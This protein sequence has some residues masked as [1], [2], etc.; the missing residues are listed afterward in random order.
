M[1]NGVFMYRTE[2]FVA[3]LHKTPII[4]L[5]GCCPSMVSRGHRI[6][7]KERNVYHVR[8]V[9]IRG[10]NVAVRVLLV[11]T[12]FTILYGCGKASPPSEEAQ[13]GGS[14]EPTQEPIFE[15]PE[16]MTPGTSWQWQLTGKVD[17]SLA[18]GAYDID[19][20]DNGSAVVERVHARGAK[21]ICYISAGSW[22]D[23]RP[24]ASEFPDSV[25]GRNNVWPGEKWL[26]IRRLD[27]LRPIMAKR[28]DM[29]AA[30]GFDAVEPDNVDGYANKTGFPLTYQ[31]QLDYNRMLADMAHRRGLAVALKNDTDQVKVLQPD[32][33]FAVVEECFRHKE[34]GMYSPFV[35]AGKAVLATEY[36]TNKM[37]TECTSARKLRFS[38]IFKNLALG[39]WRRAC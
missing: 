38:L 6:G 14:T 16:P 34:C 20:F 7:A 31:D 2:G 18:V 35:D 21:A 33:D 37:E 4:P 17:T 15:Q 29:C 1:P 9:A 22:E 19:G 36:S 28:M 23:W 26:D 27:A 25:K 5:G 10:E 32:F 3:A 30:K 39:A 11:V 8:G 12:V 24:D 13:K